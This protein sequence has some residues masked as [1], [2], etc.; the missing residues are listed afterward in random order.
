MD[1]QV[2]GGRCLRA[3]AYA[4]EKIRELQPELLIAAQMGGHEATDWEELAREVQ[5]MGV[6]RVVLVG[7]VPLWIPSLPEIVTTRFWDS[8]FDRVGYGLMP[9]RA[10]EDQRLQE[11]YGDS[12]TLRYVSLISHLCNQDG[13]Q[14]TVPGTNPP[15][16]MAFDA[17]HLTPLGSRY[18]AGQILRPILLGQ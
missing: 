16:L 14:A 12:N 3:N 15:E 9:E 7:P 18:V 8:G 1:P 17:S 10:T 11:I 4:I 6:K 5:R 2:L 13:C